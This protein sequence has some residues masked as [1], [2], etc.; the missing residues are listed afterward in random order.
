[1]AASPHKTMIAPAATV[2]HYQNY[3]PRRLLG[4]SYAIDNGQNFRNFQSAWTFVTEKVAAYRERRRFP[5]NFLMHCRFLK[6]SS[7]YLA[8]AGGNEHTCMLEIFSYIGTE[9]QQRY[10]TEIEDHW[11]SLGGRPHWGKVYSS[12]LDFAK[13]YGKR[14]RH[15]NRIRRRLD[16]RGRFLNPFMRELFAA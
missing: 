9:D 5:Q 3:F 15:F 6:N 11:L 12:D 13:I 7:G 2:F 1:M 14:L 16:P 4:L 8:P 10:F